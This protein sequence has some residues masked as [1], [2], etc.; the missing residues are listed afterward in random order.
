MKD[1]LIPRARAY[2]ERNQLRISHPLGSGNHGSVFVVEGNVK[3]NRSAIKVHQEP[4]PYLREK[5]AYERLAE[6]EIVAVEGFAIPQFLGF[7]DDLLVLEMTV[8]EPPFIVDFASAYLD[9]PPDFP[10]NVLEEWRQQKGEEF[11]ERWPVVED[12]MMMFR[13]HGVYLIDVHARN[14]A[15]LDE[16]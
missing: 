3:A 1:A 8:V 11:G 5:D 4:E 9:E 16:T 6:K 13:M 14:I 10:E 7:D 15:F 2:A 12:V